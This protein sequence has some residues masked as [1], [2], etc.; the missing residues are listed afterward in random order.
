MNQND[1]LEKI[2]SYLNSEET[3]LFEQL[4]VSAQKTHQ[5]V[6]D[7]SFDPIHLSPQDLEDLPVEVIAQLALSE[8]DNY[9]L[10]LIRLV[11]SVGG[12]ISLDK[13]IVLLYRQTGQIAD[14]SQ[15]N[16]RLN[17]MMRKG[18]IYNVPKK[19]GVYTTTAYKGDA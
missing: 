2:R 8:S 14:R 12:M 16:A 19:K 1:L 4:L 13:L 6:I 10:E 5:A 9:E 11:N 15:L 7:E 18:M 3:Q 17:R